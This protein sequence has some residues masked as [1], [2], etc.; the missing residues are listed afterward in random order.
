MIGCTKE[1]EMK[2]KKAR[3]LL[4]GLIVMVLVLLMHLPASASSISLSSSSI[5][6]LEGQG[7][8]IKATVS[9]KSKTVKW[10]SSDTR[11]AIVKNGKITVRRAGTCTI[12]ATANGKTAS[13]RVTVKPGKW[14]TAYAN[15]LK[16]NAK[17]SENRF[18]LSYIDPGEVPE[19]VIVRGYYH[20]TTAEVY[21]YVNG[22]VVKIDEYGSMAAMKYAPRTG[23][24]WGSYSGMGS[25][26][27]TF[28]LISNHKSRIVVNFC[29]H[30]EYS[31]GKITSTVCKKNNAV[32]S[33]ASYNRQLTAA[34]RKVNYHEVGYY[35]GYKVNN[36]NIN[37]LLSNPTSLVR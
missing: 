15:F 16:K 4:S 24:V 29:I 12:K 27:D 8:T 13:C 7:R 33:K 28:H 17:A 30:N 19:L 2:T 31:G 18:W 22:K 9:G 6:L 11:I 32:I 25:V 35:K 37:V 1:K 26:Y 20:F 36:T 23:R 34:K 10:S 21:S 3:R 14:R 5:T